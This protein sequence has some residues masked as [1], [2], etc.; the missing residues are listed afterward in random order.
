MEHGIWSLR[1][2]AQ[3]IE[4]LGADLESVVQ[5]MN[6][7][8]LALI[9]DHLGILNPGIPKARWRSVLAGASD[10]RSLE[11]SC[12]SSEI[13][14][15]D[16]QISPIPDR[17]SRSK[18]SSLLPGWAFSVYRA[19]FAQVFPSHLFRCRRELPFQASL[20]IDLHCTR[21]ALAM[22]VGCVGEAGIRSK[23]KRTAGISSSSCDL[24]GRKLM[25]IGAS[26]LSG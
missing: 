4:L 6:G 22:V 17:R 24:C 20:A 9:L 19:C 7:G 12:T 15:P 16:R 3:I 18:I 2:S 11:R 10:L 21:S 8:W 5:K 14:I 23:P 13:T 1:S 26:R 25:T